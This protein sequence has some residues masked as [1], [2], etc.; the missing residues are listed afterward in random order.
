[1]KKVFGITSLVLL[2]V[3][4][5]FGGI[6][7]AQDNTPT[8]PPI[9]FDYGD[10]MGDSYD[11]I[12]NGFNMMD[13]DFMG[14]FADMLNNNPPM[15]GSASNWMNDYDGNMWGNG[16]DMSDMMDSYGSDMSDMMDSYGSD[17][18][19]MMDSY[20]SGIMVPYE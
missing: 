13:F 4:F 12:D 2:S 1:M 6:A 8:P 18:S 20:G 9:P 17:M 19:D 10:M 14:N 7:F 3:L 5:I 16:S 15:S 11:G